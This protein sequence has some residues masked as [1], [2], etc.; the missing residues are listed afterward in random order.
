MRTI[1]PDSHSSG[2][3]IPI[4]SG[5]QKSEYSTLP[6]SAIWSMGFFSVTDQYSPLFVFEQ[7][8][9]SLALKYTLEPCPL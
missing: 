8:S 4:S 1:K 5:E 3:L 7:I 2:M 9:I 6:V